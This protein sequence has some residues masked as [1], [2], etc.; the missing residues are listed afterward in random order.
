MH[1]KISFQEKIKFKTGENEEKMSKNVLNYDFYSI[2]G[3]TKDF[4]IN[5]FRLIVVVFAPT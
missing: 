3:N 2:S 1:S 5:G 4:K